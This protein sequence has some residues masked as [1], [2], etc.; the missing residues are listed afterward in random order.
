M[1]EAGFPP[2]VIN[3][4]S[5]AGKTGAL[6]ASHPKVAKISFTG[7]TFV[8]KIIQKL[9]VESNMKKVTLELGGKSPAIVFPD[10]DIENAVGSYVIFLPI[11]PAE[12]R[13]DSDIVLQTGFY[14]IQH[15]FVLVSIYILYQIAP[16]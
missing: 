11:F 14:L 7:S 2:G 16:L 10:A 3:F 1:V 12:W 13:I 15:R 6:L 5:G 4:V 8:G 9:A